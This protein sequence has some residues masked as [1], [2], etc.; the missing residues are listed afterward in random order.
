MNSTEGLPDFDAWWDYDHPDE[1]EKRFREL[2]PQAAGD[3]DYRAQLLTQVARTQG[4]QR[5]FEA[6]HKTLDEAES[7]LDQGTVRARIRTLLERGRVF[8]SA[9]NP[10][11]ALPLFHQA[12]ELASSAGEDFYAIDAAHM[13]GIASPASEQLQWNLKALEGAEKSADPRARNWKGSLYNN[14]G[15]TYHDQGQ[16]AVALDYFQKA[17]QFRQAQGGAGQIRVA[18]WCV[19]RALRS[20]GRVREA[21]ELQRSLLDE[22]DSSGEADGFVYEELGECLFELDQSDE[23]Q[24]Y[25]ALAYKLLSQDPWLAESEPERIKRLKE[26]GV[27]PGSSGA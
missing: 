24:P 13:V 16:Y 4:L 11:A 5:Q 2:L 21:L 22:C 7:L 18:R 20:L 3:P 8:N 1:T 19:A 10:E 26:L 9:G 15:W 12:R 6:A 25:F 23:A 14:I 27:A 17:L